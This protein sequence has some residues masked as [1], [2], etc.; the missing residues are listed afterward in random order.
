VPQSKPKINVAKFDELEKQLKQ[1][2]TDKAA[3]DSL[4]KSLD[5]NGN[6]IVSLAEIDKLV[7][8]SLTG[9]FFLFSFS[10]RVNKVLAVDFVG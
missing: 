1:T 4:W 7:V 10:L 3:V 2:L 5:F 9:F 6:G 8:R